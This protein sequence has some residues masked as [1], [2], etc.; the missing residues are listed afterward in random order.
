MA[1]LAHLASLQRH[2]EWADLRLLKAR[3]PAGAPVPEALRE[4]AH[5]RGAQETWLARIEARA[6][7]LAVWPDPPM[8]QLAIVGSGVDSGWR[9]YHQRLSA[10]ELERRVSYT[11]S[12]GVSFTTPVVEILLHVAT[13]GQYHRGKVNA[14]LR[15]AGAEPV[16]VDYIMWQ[17]I[18]AEG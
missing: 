9:A 3:G 14:A 4:L 17:R 12:A 16:G 18:V 7:T 2:G 5:V 1:I 11:N 13:H 10:A 6:P 8:D 15:A